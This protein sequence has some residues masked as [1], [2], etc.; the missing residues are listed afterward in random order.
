MKNKTRAVRLKN[1]LSNEIWICEDY[2]NI[3]EIDGVMFIEV[4]K[5]NN[6]RK[7]WIRRDSLVKDKTRLAKIN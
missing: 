4:H 6:F 1:I 7:L 2:N 3:R 5:E